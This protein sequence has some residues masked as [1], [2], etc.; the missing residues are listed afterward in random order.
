MPPALFVLI[1]FLVFSLGKLENWDLVPYG[2]YPR[3][4]HGAVGMITY[5]FIHGSWKHLFN[6]S[7]PLLV[8]GTLL[9][10][11]YR[12]IAWKAFLWIWAMS[13]LW[14][15]IEGRS[16]YHIG[17]SGL[18][19]GLAAFVF[20]SGV[21]RKEK[22]V[23]ALS[24]LVAFLYGSIWWGMLPYD[25]HISYEGHIW[26]ALAGA[27]TAWAL[28][29]KGPQR[30]RYSWEFEEDEEGEEWGEAG[31]DGLQ[32]KRDLETGSLTP[33]KG[34]SLQ[35]HPTKPAAVPFP[36]GN[37]PPPPR[38]LRVRYVYKANEPKPGSSPENEEETKE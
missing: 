5:P 13:S 17:A 18:V 25:P 8:L 31:D 24:L 26:G 35:E 15:W 21:L 19:Y 23:A 34:E 36:P 12:E 11:F 14:L 32:E 30:K 1:L 28:R 9:F 33:E 27:A 20:V 38:Y 3:T 6:N 22:G 16:A 37:Y 4:G 29:K 2:L 7:V 10:Y